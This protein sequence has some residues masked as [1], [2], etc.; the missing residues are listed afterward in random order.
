VGGGIW[1]GIQNGGLFRGPAEVGIFC[2]KPLNFG[3]EAH[4]QTPTRVALTRQPHAST[5]LYADRATYA[6]VPRAA[7]STAPVLS[8]HHADAPH[9]QILKPL[10]QQHHPKDEREPLPR[11]PTGAER[12]SS[13][14]QRSEREGG[15]EG[16]R[17]EG[18]DGAEWKHGLDCL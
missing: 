15:R 14:P 13:G 10:D 3:V 7:T 1:R 11:T 18:L 12:V 16:V 9:I 6:H 8:T 17:E 5:P 4:T 2:T